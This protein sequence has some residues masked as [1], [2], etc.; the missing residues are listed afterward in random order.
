L[1]KKYIVL[2]LFI[3]VGVV[4]ANS[5]FAMVFDVTKAQKKLGVYEID[6]D[7]KS[8]KIQTYGSGV[9]SKVK[10]FTNK[11][12]VYAKRGYKKV[13]FF[14]NNKKNIFHIWT[15][16]SALDARLL[17][18]Y[19]RKF[20][21]VKNDDMLFIQ[22]EGRDRIELFNKHHIIIKTLDEVLLDIYQKKIDYKTFILFDKMGIMKMVATIKQQQDKY[23]IVNKYKK[24]GYIE[25]QVKDNLP[26]TIKS[27]VSKWQM[28]LQKSGFY[29]EHT[30]EVASTLKD[31]V[32]K[33]LKSDLKDATIT[34]DP[35]LKTTRSL[36]RF[37]ATLQIPLPSDITTQKKYKQARYCKKLLK[38]NRLKEKKVM[39]ENGSCVATIAMKVS[40]KKYN[41]EMKA[42]LEKE[43]KELKRT[44]KIRF[45]K[46]TVKYKTL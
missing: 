16:K 14:K 41:K 2:L 23:I 33:Q 46:S 39:I 15:K 21:K 10:F 26:Q 5:E 24:K 20:K 4:S 44:H 36:Y 28:K 7:T 1:L 43:H 27:L 8:K 42:K 9:V 40:R 17:K 38:H 11:Q 18:E 34:I 6:F 37:F 32:A 35:K 12:I 25:I 45:V 29:K 22:R 13:A 30:I 3:I 19:D 31:V